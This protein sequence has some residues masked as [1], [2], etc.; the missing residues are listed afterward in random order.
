MAGL[1]RR[2]SPYVYALNN[3]L[4]YI[5][6]NGMWNE[7]ATGWT[8]SDPNEIAAFFK[9]INAGGGEDPKKKKKEQQQ[10]EAR[11]GPETVLLGATK[12]VE[13]V[14]KGGIGLLGKLL[15]ALGAFFTTTEAG[16][17][18]TRMMDESERQR[19]YEL[20]EKVKKAGG[21]I[22]DLKPHEQ[23]E[24]KRLLGKKAYEEKITSAFTGKDYNF[25]TADYL[26][27]ILD[28]TVKEYHDKIKPIIKKDFADKLKKIGTTNPDIGFDAVGNLV[29]K[30]PST[31]KT[32]TT[33]FPLDAYKN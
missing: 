28:V 29:F 33:D 10:Q 3:P 32:I 22:A 1:Y 6:P 12:A 2:T 19:F 23:E 14:S 21:S 11:S 16:R 24:Y 5:D 7:T 13:Q 8:T 20:E 9:S 31:G 25:P 15:G 27:K 4:R 30:N 17:G 26:A 18:S